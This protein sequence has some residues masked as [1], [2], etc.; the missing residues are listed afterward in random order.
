MN[1]H[2]DGTDGR[3]RIVGGRW[4]SLTSILEDTQSLHCSLF[5]GLKVKIAPICVMTEAFFKDFSGKGRMKKNN[6]KADLM[7]NNHALPLTLKG[8]IVSAQ[9][10]KSS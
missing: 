3:V 7:I 8:T 6:K 5:K 9:R 1:G 10:R 2:V 4:G